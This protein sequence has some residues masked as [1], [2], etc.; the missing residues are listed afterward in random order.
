MY[1]I[2]LNYTLIPS[3][4]SSLFLCCYS[5]QEEAQAR[6]PKPA[7]NP[8]PKPAS[9]APALSKSD[10]QQLIAFLKQ[11]NAGE[12]KIPASKKNYNFYLVTYL[13]NM[14]YLIFYY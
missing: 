12:F 1:N 3:Y 10:Q 7:P 13:H 5:V 11:V 8:A 4:A 6:A 2:T 14:K 9:S